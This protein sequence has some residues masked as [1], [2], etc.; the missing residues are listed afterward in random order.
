MYDICRYFFMRVKKRNQNALSTNGNYLF[1][2][3]LFDILNSYLDVINNLL[4]AFQRVL[5][6]RY[7]KKV[8][9]WYHLE[10]SCF[11]EKSFYIL[12]KCS[13]LKIENNSSW[14][15]FTHFRKKTLLLTLELIFI[16]SSWRVYMYRRSKK[17]NT[18]IYFNTNHRTEMK[19][20]PIIMDYGLLLVLLAPPGVEW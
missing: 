10:I 19:L 2:T 3:V 11:Y 8:L 9:Y 14:V 6:P 17:L 18:P 5:M 4:E 20:V 15:N 1:E 16:S 12:K 13:L 7:E